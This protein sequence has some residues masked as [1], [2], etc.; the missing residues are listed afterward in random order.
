MLILVINLDSY[1]IIVLRN[2]LLK[3]SFGERLNLQIER[4][5]GGSN[6]RGYTVVRTERLPPVKN[7]K[8]TP[9]K[10]RKDY[11]P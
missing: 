1:S 7:G 3:L 10:E 2:L 6:K 11:P 8:V 5:P 9:R 4:S